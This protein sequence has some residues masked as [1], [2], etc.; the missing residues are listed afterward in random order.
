[1]TEIEALERAK[2][3]GFATVAIITDNGTAVDE[4]NIDEVINDVKTD[5][6]DDNLDHMEE[7]YFEIVEDVIV[8]K[9]DYTIKLLYALFMNDDE[10]ED[11][12]DDSDPE[13]DYEYDSMG[14]HDD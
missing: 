13:M 11:E 2:E 4:K 6:Q 7:Y 1:M 3:L 9:L 10:D 8:R 5:L 14:A 12:Y